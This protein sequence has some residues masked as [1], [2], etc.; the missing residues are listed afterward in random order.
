MLK[1]SNK[2]CSNIQ[3]IQNTA[4]Q[5]GRLLRRVM[6]DGGEGISR[7]ELGQL[8]R[9]NGSPTNIR[10]ALLLAASDLLLSDITAVNANLLDTPAG[11]S[12]SGV[13]GVT[14]DVSG[15]V[16]TT[17]TAGSSS[18]SHS[19]A[20]ADRID[21]IAP[22]PYADLVGTLEHAFKPVAT[23][24][25][26]NLDSTNA[27]WHVSIDNLFS[28]KVNNITISKD[29]YE[30]VARAVVTLN[31]RMSEF[32]LSSTEELED[33]IAMKVFYNGNAV[34]SFFPNLGL[35]SNIGTII[36]A[37]MAWQLDHPT[38]TADD[39]LDY[40]RSTFSAYL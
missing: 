9:D 16:V 5:F 30:R 14:S 6:S 39:C 3:S 38:G 1:L 19:I 21:T 15:S 24:A 36:S 32:G 37:Q 27:Q 23:D 11:S 10:F 35:W 7:S 18:F 13:V 29:S 26:R 4:G 2:D 31:Q 40:L 12:G 22:F 8:I 28:A 33:V 34:K 25:G 20:P 17:T